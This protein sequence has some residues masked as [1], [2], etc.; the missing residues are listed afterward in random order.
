MSW[1]KIN[2]LNILILVSNMCMPLNLLCGIKAG[3]AR[4]RTKYSYSCKKVFTV[5]IKI[6]KLL[7]HQEIV[8]PTSI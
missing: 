3:Y 1:I 4:V 7:C 8:F 5:Y 6:L 2:L